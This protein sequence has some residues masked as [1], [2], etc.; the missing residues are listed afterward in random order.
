MD[1]TECEN[2]DR[3]G[4]QT[5]D[6]LKFK[7]QNLQIETKRLLSSAIF[8]GGAHGFQISRSWELSSDQQTLT[9]E[10][11]F[12]SKGY[13]STGYTETFARRPSLEVA[14]EQAE[15]MS[16]MK[17]CDESLL[18][19]TKRKSRGRY[20]V[21]PSGSTTFQQL[22]RYVLFNAS[23]SAPL[24]P[25]LVR[26]NKP[27]GAEFYSDRQ[28]VRFYPDWFALQVE[29]GVTR[30]F[31]WFAVPIESFGVPEDLL[32][33]R[34]QVKWTGAET[35]DMG[36][37]PSG[38]AT[39]PWPESLLDLLPPSWRT[40]PQRSYYTLQVP[41]KNVPLTDSLESRILSSAGGPLGCI[42]G[43]I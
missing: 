26:V 3:G 9:V 34:F 11:G 38:F 43:H 14:M 12:R 29:L 4:F 20:L 41:A 1:G 28:P 36:E 27:G 40:L 31:D 7:N 32:N 13:K 2:V 19:V 35:Q 30:T 17:K 42:S 25:K 39:E 16:E 23:L 21:G 6:Q 15:A 22:G 33:L 37:V 8:A 24:F 5:T 10:H 18:P